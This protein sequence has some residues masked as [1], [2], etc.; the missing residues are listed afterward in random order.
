[1]VLTQRMDVV[2]LVVEGKSFLMELLHGSWGNAAV[3]Q[4]VL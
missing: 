3:V 1:M 2:R 4:H